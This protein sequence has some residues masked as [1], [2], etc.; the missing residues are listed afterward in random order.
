M[1]HRGSNKGAAQLNMR[2]WRPALHGSPGLLNARRR[3][4][5][6]SQSDALSETLYKMAQVASGHY[7]SHGSDSGGA[8]SI[9]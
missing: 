5:I 2:K 8:V 1:R 4:L 7:T 3:G 6:L 9:A